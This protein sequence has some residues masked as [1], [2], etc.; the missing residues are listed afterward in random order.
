MAGRLDGKV[1]IIT[2]ATSGIGEATA[3]RF[4][5]EG[6]RLII[7]G[8]TAD[9][10]AALAEELGSY[11]VFQRADVLNE[12]D[13]AALVDTAQT[14]FGRLDCLFN[15]AGA[16][17]PCK[18]ESV[19]SEQFSKNMQLLVGSVVFGIKHAIRVMKPQGGGSIINNASVAAHRFGQGDV[20]YSTAKAAVAHLTRLAG[21]ELGPFGIRVNA[22]SPGAIATPI[23]WGGSARANT[24]SDAENQAKLAKLEANLAKATPLPRTGHAVDIANAALFLASDEGSFVNSHDL[25][26][27]GGRIW[28]FHEKT[29]S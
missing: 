15:N 29:A 2:G 3:R 22:I 23:F 14:R 20:L 9:K 28:Q 4:A 26:V 19:T 24:L 16:A 5:E 12:A 18:L 7:A 1:A 21:V 6:A 13:I 8:R 25:V 17:T 27:D 11:V 10:G